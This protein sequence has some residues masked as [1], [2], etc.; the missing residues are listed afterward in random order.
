MTAAP[1]LVV[2]GLIAAIVTLLALRRAASD[3]LRPDRADGAIGALAI[4]ALIGFAWA[5]K[6]CM[7]AGTCATPRVLSARAGI[8]MTPSRQVTPTGPALEIPR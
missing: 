1:A 2:I 4:V 5:T 3:R 6:E 7:E 8:E